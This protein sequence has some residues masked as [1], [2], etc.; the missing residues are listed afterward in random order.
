MANATV[1]DRGPDG[2]LSWMS[3]PRRFALGSD[4]GQ[5]L[6]V[7]VEVMVRHPT[8]PAERRHDPFGIFWGERSLA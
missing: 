5:R 4:L 1:T 2:T 7:S 3:E 8:G 6:S